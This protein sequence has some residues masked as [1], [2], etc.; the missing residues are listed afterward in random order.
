MR[1]HRWN[2]PPQHLNGSM[3]QPEFERDACGIGFVAY[4]TPAPE[5]NVVPLALQA[6]ANM[7]HR[8]GVAA[9]GKTSDGAGILCRLPYDFF[10]HELAIR[11]LTPPP[12]G[13]LAVGMLFLPTRP[14]AR[15][16][17][18]DLIKAV[19]LGYGLTPLAWREVPTYD[20]IL[21]EAAEA[22]KPAIV[23]VLVERS[24]AVEA[25]APFERTLYL[26]RRAIE[27]GVGKAG[28]SDLYICSL[29]SRTIVYKGLLLG[30]KLG[31][32]YVDLTQPSFRSAVAIFHQRYSTNTF[33][34]WQRAQPLRILCHNGEINTIQ[35]NVNWM[36]AR[37]S[38]LHSDLWQDDLEVLKPVI[39]ETGSDS[40]MLD[41]VLELLY[42]AGRTL[43]RAMAMTIP[44]AWESMP[45]DLVPQA[46]RDFFAYHATLMEPWD[47]PAAIVFTDGSTVGMTLDR[48]GLRPARY[49]Q[50][51]DGL[52][53]AGSEAGAVPLDP[54]RIVRKG[55]LGPGQMVVVDTA[56]GEFL[57]DDA[58]KARLAAEHPYHEWVKNT[59]ALE[60]LEEEERRTGDEGRRMNDEKPNPKS[61][62]STLPELQ[63]AFGY[64]AEE[65][66]VVLR[67]MAETGSEPIGSMGDDTPPA[68]ISDKPR[69][70]YHYLKQ[71]FAQVTN[72]PIDPLR[73]E[74]VMSL[75][76]LIGQRGNILVDGPDRA[77]QLK[78]NSPV[79]T[80]EQL[81]L[82]RRLTDPVFKSVTLDA[83]YPL[84]DGEAGLAPA[85]ERLVAE[86]ET[87]VRAGA[88][89][90]II[91][92]RAVSPERV[93]VPTLL[94]AGAVHH[95]L[96]GQGLR[97]RVSLVAESGDVRDVHQ[98][99]T[100]IGYGLEAVNPYLA[101]ASVAAL[102][103]SGKVKSSKSASSPAR[104]NIDPELAK[105]HF[106]QAL[107]K[108]LRKIMSK[109]GIS[110]VDSYCGAQIFEALGLGQEVIDRCLVGTPSR[111]GGA[112][113][114]D[115]AAD[116][117]TWHADAYGDRGPR[118]DSPGFYKFKRDGE[119][120]AFSPAVIQALHKA[121]RS[122]GAHNGHAGRAE[123]YETYKD[124]VR[125]TQETAHIT[126]HEALQ[127]KPNRPPIPLDEVEPVEAIVRRFSTAAMSHGAL[128]VEAHQTLSIAM[129][130]LG[131]MSNSGE[132][133]EDPARYRDERNSTIKQVASGRFGVTPSYLMSARE[134]QIKMAQGSKPGEGG[135]LPG[136]KVT[137]EIAALRH[138]KPGVGL[139]SPPPHHDIYSIEDLSQLIFDLKQ[140][141]PQAAVSVK[142]VAEVGVGTIAAGVVKGGADV[143]H[144][145]GGSGGTGASP[146]SSI[147]NAGLPFEMGLAEAQQT[148]MANDLRDRVRLRIDGG[149]KTG[150]D[151]VIAAMLGADEFSFGTAALVAEGCLMA[152]ACHTNTCPVGIA[153]Q[154][155]ELR[156]KFPGRPEMVMAYLTF[157][158]EE[159][160][161]IL[162]GLGFRH[163]HEIIGRTD[164]LH[165]TP[166]GNRQTDQLNLSPMLKN[167]DPTWLLPRRNLLPTNDIHTVTPLNWRLVEAGRAAIDRGATVDLYLPIRNTDRT[168][169]ATLAGAI[170]AR[171]GDGGLPKGQ[172]NLTFTGTAGQSFGAFNIPGMN[173]TV[174]G[175]ANDYVGKG[176]AG[177]QIV[178][179][180]PPDTP[181]AAR[182]A[183]N[184]L[185]G[186]TVLYGATGGQLFANGRAGE[187]FAVRN[188]GATAVVEGVGDHGC[189]YMTGGT[190]V[191][192]GPVGAN[193]GAGM[194][195]GLAFVYDERGTFPSHYNDEL[196]AIN[197]LTPGSPEAEA[198]HQL[199]VRHA[200][201]TGSQKAATL[202][203]NWDRELCYFWRVVPRQARASEDA[204]EVETTSAERTGLEPNGAGR[205]GR[206]RPSQLSP[207]SGSLETISQ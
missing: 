18:Q 32:F 195:G 205:N 113:L 58:L 112:R 155:P 73:E 196:V 27:K 182:A 45:A 44:E 105:Q 15:D 37:E 4:Q 40:A 101:L 98:L 29:S 167:V 25:G 35:G 51:D 126:P 157:V 90:V 119:R 115:L 120:H 125:A 185:I 56:R 74:M 165:Q 168:V 186:N 33:P 138:S 171:F 128:S 160:R 55:K 145:S 52:I 107:E 6:L 108:G 93:P 59:I 151:V 87:A 150:R 127:F 42:H 116:C 106:I 207:I 162:A 48:N 67:P 95:H 194:T 3:Y 75:T 31:E 41:N 21:G 184:T 89:I 76:I 80:D 131:G 114:A 136:H 146:L 144:I 133:G 99:A 177:G 9:D 94:A 100:V 69:P 200:Q 137:A 28:L 204:A 178:V 26:A 88:G 152:R 38:T 181:V 43:P 82:L 129:N 22:T 102:A 111:L 54:A 122:A 163:L 64:T 143:V 39:D 77:R 201:K 134:L 192:L 83:T 174:I 13:D 156:A 96:I 203:A 183:D 17:A 188:S 173:L 34:A 206:T 170:A 180:P 85:L 16:R 91:S 158:A 169:G 103:D 5:A 8:G 62:V 202:L 53:V 109:M 176:M 36:R 139:I 175:E 141:N 84:T 198:L 197:R 140:V 159:V 124:F 49:L 187:R 161:E 191:V 70:V 121:V 179:V 97:S 117:L 130:R 153:T 92:D 65:L 66:T 123:A 63:A 24:A 20:R 86:A 30:D 68:A 14:E 193:F 81:T 7:T 11:D 172:I 57:E 46:R 72:P 19:L 78:L 166:T 142:L 1:H 164:L 132:G 190:V 50:T 154:R 23:Q 47:G 199:V 110:T 148:L 61:S 10:A 104:Q 149:T 79:L 71:R 118:L 2:G 12:P 189:E 147:K 135:H 60:E